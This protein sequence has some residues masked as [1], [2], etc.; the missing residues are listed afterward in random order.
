MSSPSKDLGNSFG[1][2]SGEGGIYTS[3][4][5]LSAW[6]PYFGAQKGRPEVGYT[7]LIE[8]EKLNDEIFMLAGLHNNL[9]D[10]IK[11]RKI[12]MFRQLMIGKTVEIKYN[13]SP[14]YS[15]YPGGYYMIEYKILN[16]VR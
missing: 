14:E 3:K 16:L 10:S 2:P 9:T 5:D 13:S 8:L 6:L 4:F 15:V 11:H 12:S 7:S 1:Y